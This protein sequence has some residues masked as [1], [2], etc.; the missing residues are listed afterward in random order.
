MRIL[1][2]RQ[3]RHHSLQP[4]D[5]ADSLLKLCHQL[6]DNALVLGFL[7]IGHGFNRSSSSRALSSEYGA[8][9]GT[10]CSAAYL[11]RNVRRI[12]LAVLAART[13]SVC[14]FGLTTS[15]STARV[16]NIASAADRLPPNSA[17]ISA[18]RAALTATPCR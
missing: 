14:D 8:G 13:A 1:S 7:R 3:L 2:T 11:A 17:E 5:F 18:L 6:S 15:S 16:T 10:V 12:R 4:I 9:N